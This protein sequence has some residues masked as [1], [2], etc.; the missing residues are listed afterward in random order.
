MFDIHSIER[1]GLLVGR[2]TGVLDAKAAEQIVV[3]VET[4]EL[5]AEASFNR[6]C[7]MTHLDGIHLSCNDVL[8]IAARRRA[9]NPNP[10]RVKSAFFATNPL[11]FGIARM[12]EQ[13]LNSSRIEVR[14][15]SDMQTAAAWLGVGVETLTL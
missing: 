4:K 12:Y 7:D 3:F 10:I 11:A 6:F 9:F 5:G 2:F 8:Q 15:W 13:M 1:D 14:V